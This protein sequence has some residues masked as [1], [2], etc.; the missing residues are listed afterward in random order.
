MTLFLLTE[1]SSLIIDSEISTKKLLD[2]DL[3]EHA[4]R[5]QIFE[6]SRLWN[7]LLNYRKLISY[8][9]SV[10]DDNMRG[11]NVDPDLGGEG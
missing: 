8:F 9:N 7:I 4:Q 2:P 6:K 1:N 5:L 11:K 10:E 3:H